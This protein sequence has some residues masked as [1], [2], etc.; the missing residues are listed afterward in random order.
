MD[1]EYLEAV[2]KNEFLDNAPLYMASKKVQLGA[3]D[4]KPK[5]E[6]VMYR[7][8]LQEYGNTVDLLA[9]YRDC[10]T[11]YN[12]KWLL[13]NT[14]ELA[15]NAG[16]AVDGLLRKENTKERDASDPRRTDNMLVIDIFEMKDGRKNL[17]FVVVNSVEQKWNPADPFNT[18]KGWIAYRFYFACAAIRQEYKATA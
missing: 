12:E 1:V 2:F 4:L 9:D 8:S 13:E 5:V 6:F 15:R 18:I 10:R 14:R 7:G 17:N 11:E 16:I 3:E